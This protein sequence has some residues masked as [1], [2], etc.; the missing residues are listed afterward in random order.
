ME[1]EGKASREYHGQKNV[2]EDTDDEEIYFGQGGFS[3]LNLHGALRD[4][5]TFVQL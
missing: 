2:E 1:S 5:K 3:P 4:Q